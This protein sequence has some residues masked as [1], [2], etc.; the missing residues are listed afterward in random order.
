MQN[1]SKNRKSAYEK[2]S[3]RQIHKN[4]HSSSHTAISSRF[5]ISKKKKRP[6]IEIQR[7]P[8]ARIAAVGGRT[9]FIHPPPRDVHSLIPPL[10]VP[11]SKRGNHCGFFPETAIPD[12][13]DVHSCTVRP[14]RSYVA[15]LP[16]PLRAL[17]GEIIANFS[18]TRFGRRPPTYTFP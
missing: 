17:K 14:G 9:T 6:Q 2:F 11:G 4:V 15:S 10:P 16:V 8:I 3:R 1:V 5:A 18:E 13:R 7:C 12:S